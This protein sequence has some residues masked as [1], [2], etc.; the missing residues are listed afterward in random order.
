MING[1]PKII[2]D[3]H[4]DKSKQKEPEELWRKKDSCSFEFLEVRKF[5]AGMFG[6]PA[7]L[8]EGCAR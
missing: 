8:V 6:K 2:C 4:L 3:F 7:V 1:S 5:K